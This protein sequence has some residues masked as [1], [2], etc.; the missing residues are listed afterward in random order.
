MG[1][2]LRHSAAFRKT[3]YG[4]IPVSGTAT[5]AESGSYQL[6][7]ASVAGGGTQ[8]LRVKRGAASDYWYM[9]LRS[10]SGV[11]DNFGVADPAVSGV[12]IRLANDYGIGVRTRLIDTTPAT[13]SYA[14]APLQAGQT[15][16]DPL[17]GISITVD[18]V[19]LG[20]ATV[21][22]AL[23][24]SAP[25]DPA[26]VVPATS[27][28]PLPLP[29]P[30]STATVVLRRVAARR[31]AVRLGLRVQGAS[32][33]AVRLAAARWS[34]CR[35]LAGR[36]AL[37]RTVPLS[38][39]PVPVALRLDGRVVLSVRMQIPRIRGT[40]RIVAPVSFPRVS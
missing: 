13:G 31:A 40:T 15:F 23:P 3:E 36:I 24:G 14:D 38:G 16:A 25:T 30:S 34:A 32:R 33:C 19:V 12:G 6:A 11:F 37:A 1:T 17:S 8:S 27:P 28:P 4:F 18:A 10:P 29:P 9:E 20:T 22:V 21:R 26:P 35:V 2:A 5:V 7:S 39:G